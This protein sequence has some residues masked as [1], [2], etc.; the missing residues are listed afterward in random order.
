[1]AKKVNL[2]VDLYGR[3]ALVQESNGWWRPYVYGNALLSAVPTLAEATLVLRRAL[4]NWHDPEMEAIDTKMLNSM[5]A[6][7]EI[8]DY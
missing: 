2:G 7:G 6:R 1:M 3:T 8:L 4:D 5:T